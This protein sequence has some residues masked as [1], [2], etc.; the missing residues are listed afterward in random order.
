[1]VYSG[2]EPR[3]VLAADRFEAHLV[4]T[5][6]PSVEL[7]YPSGQWFQYSFAPLSAHL[8]PGTIERLDFHLPAAQYSVRVIDAA[9]GL[10]VAEAT[11]VT[12]N[13]YPYGE[14]DEDSELTKAVNQ[15]A[16]TDD[17]GVAL[18][19]PLHQGQLEI[20]AF[21]EGYRELVRPVA[22]E[23]LDGETDQTFEVA[24]EPLG[25]TVTVRLR[26]PGGAPAAGADVLLL[27]SLATGVSVFS[28]YASAGGEIQAPRE[29]PFGVFLVRHP[30]AAFLVRR[31]QPQDGEYEIDWTLPAA[32]RSLLVRVKDTWGEEVV[33]RAELTLWIDGWRLSGTTLTWLTGMHPNTRSPRRAVT[34]FRSQ[35]KVIFC[36]RGR[37]RSLRK[38][39]FCRKRFWPLYST[40]RARCAHG[41]TSLADQSLR[42]ASALRS[43]PMG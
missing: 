29:P 16:E 41:R 25:E 40:P 27:E 35:R 39:R 31:W 13:I 9:S 38:P 2:G 22:A 10:G 43:S 30:E 19:S 15:Q 20:R 11:V 14:E 42:R 1:M 6:D 33:P 28:G 5:D 37:F 23:V 4:P 26:L 17:E 3:D 36:L 18:L 7:V 21:A 12:R 8:R 34:P 32:G 24:L